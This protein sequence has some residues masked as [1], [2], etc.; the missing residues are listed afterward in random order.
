MPHLTLD[1]R[2]PGALDQ[3]LRETAADE[4]DGTPG[5]VFALLTYARWLAEH[6]GP[7][8]EQGGDAEA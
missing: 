2:H 3:V 1:Q 5:L 4:P 7:L 8:S 6:T